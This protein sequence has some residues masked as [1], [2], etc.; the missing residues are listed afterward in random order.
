MVETVGIRQVRWYAMLESANDRVIVVD[1]LGQQ[2]PPRVRYRM[3]CLL[4]RD[5][6]RSVP[7]SNE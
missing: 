6:V 5:A 2:V 3:T 7:C 4:I 1:T